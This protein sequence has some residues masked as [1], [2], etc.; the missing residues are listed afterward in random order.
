[1]C[2]DHAFLEYSMLFLLL[3]VASS[4]GAGAAAVDVDEPGH[5]EA[6]GSK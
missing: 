4:S 2:V 3:R 1:M 5:D 6:S